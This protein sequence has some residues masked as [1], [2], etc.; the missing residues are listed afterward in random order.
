MPRKRIGYNHRDLALAFGA[1]LNL[2]LDSSDYPV[3]YHL[4]RIIQKPCTV[5]DL[6]GNVGTH[7]LRYRKYLNLENIN[8]IVCD[9][10][11]ITKVGRERCAEMSNIEFINDF[12]EIKSAQI[13]VFLACGTLQYIDIDS[14]DP[15]LQR[16]IDM[17]KRPAH[18][19]IDVLP[20]YDGKQFVTLQNGGLVRYPQYVFNREGFIRAITNLGYDLVDLWDNRFDSCVIPFH[21]KRSVHAYTGLCFSDRQS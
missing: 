3:L 1:E 5:L 9:L 14:P 6:G 15:L 16:L 12:V 2:R 11:E 10:P 20:L 4:Q 17:G 8:W 18:I 19:L 13:D 7:Y 21:P